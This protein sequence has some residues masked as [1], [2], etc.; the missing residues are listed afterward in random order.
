MQ[1]E[2]V[3]IWDIG[4]GVLIYLLDLRCGGNSVYQGVLCAGVCAEV[5]T[6]PADVPERSGVM[7]ARR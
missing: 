3:P 2:L 6:G 5:C 4:L 1:V 7:E